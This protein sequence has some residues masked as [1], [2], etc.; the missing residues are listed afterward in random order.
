MKFITPIAE[1]E[2]AHAV[3]IGGKRREC[4]GLVPTNININS[5]SRELGNLTLGMHHPRRIGLA[6]SSGRPG[7]TYNINININ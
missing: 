1:I 3:A 6:G 2:S 5:H 4:G 7:Y